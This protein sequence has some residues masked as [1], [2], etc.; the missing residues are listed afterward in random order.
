MPTALVIYEGTGLTVVPLAE[1][2]FQ[3][4]TDG[5]PD[6]ADSRGSAPSLSVGTPGPLEPGCGLPTR[7]P[8]A[9]ALSSGE[10]A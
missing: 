4:H 1:G 2:G 10:M 8:K 7:R 6:A 5:R 9:V 3:A